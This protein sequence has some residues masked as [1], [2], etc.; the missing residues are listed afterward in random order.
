[1]GLGHCTNN[2]ECILL[3]LPHQPLRA[4]GVRPHS[5]THTLIADAHAFVC[6]SFAWREGYLTWFICSLLSLASIQIVIG[7][8]GLKVWM[9]LQGTGR[10]CLHVDT[11]LEATLGEMKLGPRMS[12]H[13]LN[14][15]PV[16]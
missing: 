15:R 1:M 3:I 8:Q 11:Y 4:A 2:A 10:R 16:V 5:H 12:L 9:I 6:T 14:R 7:Y 13:P